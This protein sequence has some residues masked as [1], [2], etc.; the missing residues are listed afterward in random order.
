MVLWRIEEQLRAEDKKA[1]QGLAPP[2]DLTLEHLLP[3]SW[4]KHW[5]LDPSLEDP[6]A[7][8][9]THMHRLGN[10]TLT[11]GRLNSALSNGP[12][13]A[14]D[15]A[16]DKRRALLAHSLLRLNVLVVIEY[17][18]QFDER[19]IDRRGEFL[20]RAITRIWPGPPNGTTPMRAFVP[21]IAST[22]AL[23]GA[24]SQE[25]S[26][27]RQAYAAF[28][29]KLLGRVRTERPDWTPRKLAPTNWLNFRC[30]RFHPA[31][32][33]MSFAQGGRLRHEL[34][35][36]RGSRE[37]SEEV[38]HSLLDER[39]RI[40]A[41]FGGP[42]EWEPLPGKQ[43]CRIAAYRHGKITDKNA[44]DAFIEWFLDS[45]DRLRRALGD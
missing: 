45:G 10:L 25:V 21:E 1:E 4:Q 8:R 44:H 30:E 34:Y 36:D 5:P 13:H 37:A 43:V 35:I 11:T 17:P 20:F 23:S 32:Y 27:R 28:W 33:A 14:P 9:E 16:T 24:V 12:W 31:Y 40:E 29:E 15:T 22:A 41:D 38:F 6:L 26:P 3:Q 18:E 2:K 39:D 19:A 7:A 42:L